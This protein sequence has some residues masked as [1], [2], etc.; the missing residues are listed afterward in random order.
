MKG[1]KIH[2]ILIVED[3]EVF[4]LGIKELIDH[5]S[6]LSVCGEADDAAGALTLLE[7]LDPDM[8][9]VDITLRNGN[10][11]DLIREICSKPRPP[12]VLV[13]SMH[14]ELLYAERCLQAGAQG[15]IMKQE[16][17]RSIV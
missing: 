7:E 4:R 3:H 1:A 5:E 10:G 2:R 17:S 12:L 6:D 13:L 14:D 15:Y 9:I 16:T 11:M 8:A